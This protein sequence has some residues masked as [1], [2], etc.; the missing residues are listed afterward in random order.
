MDANPTD[1]KHSM[2]S[3][4]TASAG[5]A[6]DDYFQFWWAAAAADY[7]QDG[8]LDLAVTQLNAVTNFD[9]YVEGRNGVPHPE[10]EK[11]RQSIWLLHNLGHGRF[12]DE[13]VSRGVILGNPQLPMYGISETKNPV[14]LDYGA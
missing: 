7:D 12:R 4:I 9:L 5:L 2:F 10:F 3:D 1:D 8:L 13:A 11:D 14:W 6:G